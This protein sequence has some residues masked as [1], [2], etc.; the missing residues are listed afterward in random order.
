LATDIDAQL[1]ELADLIDSLGLGVTVGIHGEEG[2]SGH[3]G[4]LTNVD[5]GAI[6]EYGLGVPQRSFLRQ[7]ADES[8]DAI[9]SQIEQAVDAVLGGATPQDAAQRL[10]LWA[11][12]EVKARLIA[13]IGPPLSEATKR[14]RGESAKA[15]VDT[16]QMLGS[17]RGKPEE[18]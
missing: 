2:S 6:H 4:G 12:G 18:S 7:W 17:I 13:G 1:G 5:L 8:Q 10:A 3:G 14:K 9:A 16:G 15:L 11:E